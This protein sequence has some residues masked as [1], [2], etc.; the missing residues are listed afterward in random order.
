MPVGRFVPWDYSLSN[1]FITP[2]CNAFTYMSQPFVS[3]FVV[4]ARNSQKGTTENYQGAFAKG[5]V[6][7]VAANALDGVDRSGRITL[8]PSLN[9]DKGI[10]RVNQGPI[11][12][13]NTRF[14]RGMAPEEP[15]SHLSFGLRMDDRDGKFT[16]LDNTITNMHA[17]LPGGCSGAGCD[18]V[19]LGT[20]KLLYGRLLAGKDRGVD[21]ASLPVKLLMQRF[22][23]ASWV[24][25]EE[26]DCSQLSLANNGFD[27]LPAVEPKD[28]ERK[29]GF[30]GVTASYEVTGKIP[31]LLTKPYSSSLMLSGQSVPSVSAKAKQGEIVL[32]F[33]APNVAVRI[34]YKVD[35]AN[36]PS[37]PLW[38]S[39][40]VTLQGEARFGSS[41][42][43]DRII[44]R[45]EV[46]H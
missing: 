27:P 8:F 11:I 15:F 19:L 28:P 37:Q 26:D 25:N 16:A 20:Q 42:G 32:H 38:L 22:E 36:Q 1:G 6:E 45:R 29:I 4:T 23:S 40:P 7:M 31:P 3:G 2:A 9:W 34:P 14:D 21:S 5:V 30:N 18:A 17:A 46:L 35:L 39:D 41:R 13:S 12:Q 43:N 10:A 24:I 44:Y 33:G